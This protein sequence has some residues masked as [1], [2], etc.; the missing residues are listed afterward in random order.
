V[1]KEKTGTIKSRALLRYEKKRQGKQVRPAV[2]REDL[3][4]AL[5]P[6]LAFFGFIVFMAITDKRA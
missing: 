6:V 5:A 2:A 4:L 3:A 1:E